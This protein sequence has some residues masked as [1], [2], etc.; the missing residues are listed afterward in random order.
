[1]NRFTAID[2]IRGLCLLAMAAYHFTW[3]AGY[4][5]LFYSDPANTHLGKWIAH[6]IAWSFL[7]LVGISLVL[8]HRNGIRWPAFGRRLLILLV[9][10][11]AVSAG[12]YAVFGNEFVFFGILH[13]IA[14]ASVLGLA[15]LPLPALASLAAALAV[16]LAARYGMLPAFDHP[17][18]YWLGLNVTQPYTADYQPLIPN[19]GFVLIGIVLGKGLLHAAPAWATMPAR[20]APARALS[21]L[22]RHSLIFYLAHQPV[23]FGL[24]YLAAMIFYPY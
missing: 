6:S 12:T 2:V 22:G 11:A 16:F 24:S 3:D 10:A 13:C 4:L 23:I 18:W 15:F 21:F 19:F 20:V 17:A 5:G 1:M 9:A 8:A 7:T 14:L